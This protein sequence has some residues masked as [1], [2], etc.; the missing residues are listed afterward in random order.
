MSGRFMVSKLN[1]N[2]DY[3]NVYE[4]R[5][6]VE[7]DKND[8]YRNH[9]ELY[10]KDAIR[11]FQYDYEK[12]SE[13]Q[14]MY[15]EQINSKSIKELAIKLERFVK[16]YSF[17]KEECNVI[18]KILSSNA[19]EKN[20]NFV[21]N[22]FYYESDGISKGVDSEI[23][24]HEKSF[25]FD[26]FKE[27]SDTNVDEILLELIKN[28]L[29]GLFP[30]NLLQ[31]QNGDVFIYIGDNSTKYVIKDVQKLV[32]NI[33]FCFQYI[34]ENENDIENVEA[35]VLKVE[36]ISNSDIRKKYIST[37]INGKGDNYIVFV[38]LS[39]QPQLFKRQKIYKRLFER[40]RCKID[41]IHKDC[42]GYE[43]LNIIIKQV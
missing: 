30:V 22:Q 23:I 34:I 41:L 28:E 6:Y 2:D 1:F 39:D 35:L 31:I 25:D 16:E 36:Y 12:G 11:D 24:Y 17:S 42:D 14:R 4:F 27:K 10:K 3:S 7:L 37:D 18:N 19:V 38:K 33:E 13:Y 43:I 9:A 5:H 21:Y 40:T 29:R 26:T 8:S 20:L 15:I 32:E